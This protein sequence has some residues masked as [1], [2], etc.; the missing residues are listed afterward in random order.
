MTGKMIDST[1]QTEIENISMDLLKQSKSIDVFPTPVDDIVKYANLTIDKSVD[2]S[3]I[4]N[5]Y[6][7]SI[8][9]N[10]AKK[11]IDSIKQVRGALDRN[12][13]TIYLDL[14]QIH[15]R[16]NFVKLH[17]T[18]HEVLYWQ[19]EI[20][21]HIDDDTTLDFYTSEEFEAE[22]NYFASTI[23]FQNDRFQNEISTLKLSIDTPI[24]LAKKF[25]ASNHA[26]LRKYVESSIQRCALLVLENISEKGTI[27]LCSKRDYFQSPSFS[28][29]FGK[30]NL[31]N[32]FGYTWSF[33]QDF[34]FKKRFH[35]RGKICLETENGYA[36][37]Q[38]HFF[39]N[40]YNAF[41]L[42]FPV[43]EGKL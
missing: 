42:I 33:T 17:E 28:T 29:T 27:P 3:K 10:V 37:F 32:E 34:Y 4:D 8:S 16:Q 7:T 6:L 1:S 18:G 36:D 11:T 19:N 23:L 40:T 38:Y 31:P 26:T 2:L 9:P 20:L 35:K 30:I 5:S 24:K 41:V 12:D 22:A 39:N 15:T 43:G 13:K 14:S 21:A 25:G